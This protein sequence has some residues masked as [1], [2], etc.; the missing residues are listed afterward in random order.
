MPDLPMTEMERLEKRVDRGMAWVKDEGLEKALLTVN[1]DQ[2]DMG[3]CDNCIGGQLFGDYA[4]FSRA[5]E[6][7]HAREAR[8][9]LYAAFGKNHAD[10]NRVYRKLTAIWRRRIDQMRQDQLA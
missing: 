2:L 7:T 10:T 6:L 4:T 3:D 1:T 5:F 9:G 8:L